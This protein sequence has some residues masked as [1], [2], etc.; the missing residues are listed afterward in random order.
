MKYAE[1]RVESL[2]QIVSIPRDESLPQIVSYN[3]DHN[4]ILQNLSEQDICFYSK[5][6]IDRE[7]NAV[8]L[9]DQRDSKGQRYFSS[10]NER[11]PKDSLQLA[12]NVLN[13]LP[14]K[15]P[16]NSVAPS[17]EVWN[18]GDIIFAPILVQQHAL[19]AVQ[20]LQRYAIV[21]RNVLA[22]NQHAVVK[23]ATYIPLICYENSLCTKKLPAI[24]GGVVGRSSRLP[25]AQQGLGSSLQH[26]MDAT[27]SRQSGP[28]RPAL[29]GAPMNVIYHSEIGTRIL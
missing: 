7:R 22:S 27:K 29:K 21:S 14:A 25:Y 5:G 15:F 6:L 24:F 11:L 16:A 10:F 18:I 20:Q 3:Y 28:L 2:Q 12:R 9:C 23:E 4:M 13:Q 8:D 1:Q 19:T 26:R 17:N